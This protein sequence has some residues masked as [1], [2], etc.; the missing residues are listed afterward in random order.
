M[1]LIINLINFLN[2]YYL[3][4]GIKLIQKIIYLSVIFEINMNKLYQFMHMKFIYKGH[5][6]YHHKNILIKLLIN[7]NLMK[8]F[9]EEAFIQTLI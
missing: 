7:I 3:K 6:K 2:G 1:H 5:I 9:Q 4:T 8:M